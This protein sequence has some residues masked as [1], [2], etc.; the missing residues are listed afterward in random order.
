[1]LYITIYGYESEGALQKNC[2]SSRR[3]LRH[4]S[5]ERTDD[6]A[7]IRSVK[8]LEMFI[9]S[10]HPLAK[11]IYPDIANL[12]R[13]SQRISHTDQISAGGPD[14]CHNGTN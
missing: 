11:K 10:D 5:L 7:A 8:N 3:F 4:C 13:Q 12:S 9:D 1:M 14:G 6:S 2:F